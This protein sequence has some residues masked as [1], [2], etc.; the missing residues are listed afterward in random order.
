MSPLLRLA[1][2]IVAASSVTACAA[3]TVGS[4]VER[5][6]DFSQYRTYQWGPPDALPAG[7]ARL[8]EDL[9]FVDRMQG[10]VEKALTARGYRRVT[11][12][13]P[14]L[15]VHYHAATSARIDVNAIDRAGR[16]CDGG[17][18]D[19]N[20]TGDEAATLIVDIVDA[21]TERLVW[22]GWTRDDLDTFLSDHGRAARRIN[23]AV[24]R[25][26]AQLPAG[27]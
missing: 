1:H 5:G 10:A 8:E 16:Y 26:L 19:G 12:G 27:L 7:D 15:L 3:V 11:F 18:C 24:Q 6:V 22:R 21:R 17:P 23:E 9:V 13:P 14:D 25:V 2:L 4:H 20:V